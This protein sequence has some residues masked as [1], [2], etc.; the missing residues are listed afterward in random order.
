[1]ESLN[2]AKWVDAH[3]DAI[4]VAQNHDRNKC[5]WATWSALIVYKSCSNFKSFHPIPIY[6]TV[7]YPPKVFPLFPFFGLLFD[8]SLSFNHCSFLPFF[9]YFV[10]TFSLFINFYFFWNVK[11]VPQTCSLMLIWLYKVYQMVWWTT[12][13]VYLFEETHGFLKNPT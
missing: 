2:I 7:C 8:S 9:F 3:K 11:K 6:L 13:Y 5:F 1:M 10:I 4:R 12:L